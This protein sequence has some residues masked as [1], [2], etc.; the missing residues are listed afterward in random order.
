MHDYTSPCLKN[1]DKTVDTTRQQVHFTS[2]GEEPLTTSFVCI[3]SLIGKGFLFLFDK[4]I[5]HLLYVGN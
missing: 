5:C 2:F 1:I 4:K 3:L